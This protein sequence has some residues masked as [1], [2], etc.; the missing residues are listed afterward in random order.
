MNIQIRQAQNSDSQTIYDVLQEAARWLI[1]KGE[2]LWRAD[3]ITIEQI[4]IDVAQ[5]LFYFA[6]CDGDVAG[7]IKFQLEDRAFWSDVPAAE[8]AFVHRL[9]VRRQFAGGEISTALLNWAVA[10]TRALERS[11][12]RLD[13][14]A[15]RPK[16]RAVYESFGFR[17]HSDRQVG[18]YFVARYELEV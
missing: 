15:A 12:L 9:A 6:E 11:F 17:H 14:E 5:G 7:V 13:C 1:E 8:A 2:P 16:L 18:P 4:T 3:E 10:Q